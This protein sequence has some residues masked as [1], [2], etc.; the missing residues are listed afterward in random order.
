[1]QF[2]ADFF[3]LILIPKGFWESGMECCLVFFNGSECVRLLWRLFFSLPNKPLLNG[4]LPKFTPLG[5]RRF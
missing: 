3:F 5:K 2:R 1:M 4:E